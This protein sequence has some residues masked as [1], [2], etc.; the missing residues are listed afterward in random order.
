MAGDVIA[1]IDDEPIFLEFM[2]EVL[3]DEGYR[4]EC[5]LSATGALEMIRQKRPALIILDGWMERRESGWMLFEQLRREQAGGQLEEVGKELREL[6]GTR[7]LLGADV[8][9]VG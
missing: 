1:V 5:W 7:G 3:T 4:P 6:A 2:A 8:H 9:G